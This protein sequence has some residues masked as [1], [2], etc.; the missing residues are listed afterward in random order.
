MQGAGQSR[1]GGTS[2]EGGSLDKYRVDSEASGDTL[3]LSHGIQHA[4]QRRM[5]HPPQQEAN[6]DDEDGDMPQLR[7]DQAAQAAHAANVGSGFENRAY[8]QGYPNGH[9]Y[10]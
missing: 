1:N 9:K 7:A 2:A 5:R 8:T 6:D 3:V 4:L 10:Q